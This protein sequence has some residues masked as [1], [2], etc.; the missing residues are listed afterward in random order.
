[1]PAE[2]VGAFARFRSKHKRGS[3]IPDELRAAA[4]LVLEQGVTPVE[5]QRRCGVSWGQIMA[6]RAGCLEA[7]AQ[8]RSAQE[9]E[10]RTFAVV[11]GAQVGGVEPAASTRELE[12]ELRL[13]PWS[14]R[15]RLAGSDDPVQ[16]GQPCSR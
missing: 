8:Q 15:V 13:G 4:L 14:V 6:W 11:D 10:V 12:L 2:L 5:L 3:R 9:Q 16:Q 7:V 1:M